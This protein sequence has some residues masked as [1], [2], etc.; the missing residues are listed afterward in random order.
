MADEFPTVLELVGATPIVRLDKLSPPGG[1]QILAKLEYLNPG[2]SVKDRIGLPM[3]EAAE[4]EGKLKPGGTIVEPTS[5]NTGV[6]LAIAAAIK[7]YRCIFVMPDKMSQEKIALL[8]AYG[9]EVVITPTA[10]EHDSPESYYSVSDRLAE[11]IPGGFKPDQYSNM[12]NPEAHYTHTGPEVWEQTNGGQI[13][14]IVVSVGTGGTI[15]GL[16]RYFKERK[17][18]V[19]IVG[20]DPEGSVYTAKS[21]DDLHPYLVEGIGKDTW[22]ETMDPEVVDEWVR[23]SDR[24]SFRWARRL[25]REEGL[26]SGG[27]GGTSVYAAVQIA[28]RL[29]AGKRVLM[30]IPDSGRNYLSKFYDDNWM[31]EHGFIERQAP[32][33]TVEEVLVAKHGGELPDLVTISAHQK[34][35]E[36]IDTMQRYGISQLPVI[37]DG[38][39]ES[40]ADV[41]GSLQD[42][43]LL[44]RVFTNP[45][46]L[47][48]D[49]ATAMQ[50]PLGAVETNATLDDVFATLSG[51]ANAIVVCQDGRPIG[52]LT[53][54]DLLEFLAHRR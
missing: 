24:E 5:G 36:G 46:V 18:E 12:N 37:R 7:G 52:V 17:P 38:S 49:V 26:L 45:D 34:V 35:G 13:D 22:P 19:L 28:K 16:G 44:E 41:I 53:R 50:P 1:A 4:R 32:L 42:R 31:L 10:V 8:R 39:C 30:M 14:A 29:G 21:D 25:A 20:A 27:S 54:S 51:G 9:A 23:V 47:H 33:P 6:G 43:A 48:E 11:E 40:L 15:S 3:I 2:G